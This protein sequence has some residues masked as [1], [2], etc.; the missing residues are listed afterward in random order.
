MLQSYIW[1]A[2]GQLFAPILPEK[3]Q[4]AAQVSAVLLNAVALICFAVSTFD[5]PKLGQNGDGIG[6]SF[7]VVQSHN[8]TLQL[9]DFT[10]NWVMMLIIVEQNVVNWN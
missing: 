5:I 10:I 6:W 9:R 7:M 1:L 8:Y 2:T 4:L 3:G